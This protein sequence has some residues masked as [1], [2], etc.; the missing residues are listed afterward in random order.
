MT[1]AAFL[2]LLASYEAALKAATRSLTIARTLAE[3]HRSGLHP[4]EVILEAY[5][6]TIERDEAQLAELRKKL[7]ALK[8][9]FATH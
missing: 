5:L 9:Q 1:D 6:A 3:A 8:S 4:P 7:Q 2:E